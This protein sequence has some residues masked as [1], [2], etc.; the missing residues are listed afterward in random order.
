MHFR[1]FHLFYL[2]TL[3]LLV[4]GFLIKDLVIIKAGW[5]TSIHIGM[6]SYFL[7]AAIG[8]LLTGLIYHY[9][10]H[11]GRQVNRITVILHFV[12]ASLGLLLSRNMYWLINALLQSVFPG[13]QV[14]YYDLMLFVTLSGPVLLI[15]SILIFIMGL[16]RA[17]RITY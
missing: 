15:V 11:T 10:F 5:H 7:P 9:W 3:L 13:I 17:K 1:I 12:F 8:A 2:L 6:W 16:V 14:I 4:I